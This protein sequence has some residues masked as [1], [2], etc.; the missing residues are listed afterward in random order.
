MNTSLITVRMLRLPSLVNKLFPSELIRATK[1]NATMNDESTEI[2]T[3]AS[4]RAL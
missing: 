4:L 1:K 3:I 2:C